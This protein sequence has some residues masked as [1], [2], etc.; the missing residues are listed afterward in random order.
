MTE[1]KIE[2]NQEIVRRLLAATG[3][4]VKGDRIEHRLTLCPAGGAYTARLNSV[5]VRPDGTERKIDAELFL[6]AVFQLRGTDY[7]RRI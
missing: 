4:A 7:D 3:G 1:I 2:V 5:A 6:T